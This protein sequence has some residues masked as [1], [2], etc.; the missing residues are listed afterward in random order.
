MAEPIVEQAFQ[1][2][3]NEYQ[4][5][6]IEAGFRT[7]V[8]AV[9]RHLVEFDNLQSSDVPILFVIRPTGTSGTLEHRDKELY[10][11]LLNAEV[12]GFLRHG[13]RNAEKGKL[14]TLGERFVADIKKVQM[15]D[16]RFG[17]PTVIKES[18]L[19]TDSNDAAFDQAGAMVTVGMTLVLMFDK[20][21]V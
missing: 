12:V 20:T 19:T 8:K 13:G 9:K 14:A 15:N 17:V 18:W 10:K 4:G 5:L 16:P 6:T 2:M 1:A 21:T 11:E 3:V 7:N